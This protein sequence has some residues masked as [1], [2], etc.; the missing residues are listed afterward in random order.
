MSVLQ[1]T[2][3]VNSHLYPPQQSDSL[4]QRSDSP[5]SRA[6]VNAVVRNDTATDTQASQ[7][8]PNVRTN[9]IAKTPHLAA[10]RKHD[11]SPK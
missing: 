7:S 1:T 4:R 8:P 10:T 6:A 3:T 5:I 9:H 11:P 2:H